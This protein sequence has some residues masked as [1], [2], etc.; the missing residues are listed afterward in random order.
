MKSATM[1]IAVVIPTLSLVPRGENIHT[2]NTDKT[3]RP[4][5]I[6]INYFTSSTSRGKR[7][8]RG[9]FAPSPHNPPFPL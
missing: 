7:F 6:Y 1:L 4:K 5:V 3:T 8:G 9:G 2:H